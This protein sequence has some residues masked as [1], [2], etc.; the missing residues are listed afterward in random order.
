MVNVMSSE[1]SR[2]PE[3]LELP[4]QAFAISALIQVYPSR[5]R[6]AQLRAIIGERRRSRRRGLHRLHACHGDH[7]QLPTVAANRGAHTFRQGS[8]LLI[9]LEPGT[10]RPS[11]LLPTVATC[12]YVL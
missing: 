4:L 2:G 3:S 7:R 8:L 10:T 9:H 12:K 6:R 11:A 1:S 5:A